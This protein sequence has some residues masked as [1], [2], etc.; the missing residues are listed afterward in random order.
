MSELPLIMTFAIAG[1]QTSFPYRRFTYA[2]IFVL[3]VDADEVW[4]LAVVV[5]AVVVAAAV[6]VSSAAEL[7]EPPHP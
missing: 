5:F 6:E 7:P 3:A 1:Y 4:V 2:R